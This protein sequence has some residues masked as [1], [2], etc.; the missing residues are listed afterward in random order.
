LKDKHQT[1]LKNGN[2]SKCDNDRFRRKYEKRAK[3][4]VSDSISSLIQ[5]QPDSCI[6]SLDALLVENGIFVGSAVD[7]LRNTVLL[8]LSLD[9]ENEISHEERNPNHPR[10]WFK[11]GTKDEDI[12][13]PY[14]LQIQSFLQESSLD[15]GSLEDLIS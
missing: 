7:T 2:S 13:N 1:S 8:S 3:Q 10:N 4:W 6:A 15:E 12:T 9:V 14:V 11:E 5:P